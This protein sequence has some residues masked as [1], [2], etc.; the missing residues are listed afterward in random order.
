MIHKLRPAVPL[1][2]RHLLL[3]VIIL[4]STAGMGVNPAA[5]WIPPI[6]SFP[7]PQIWWLEA[8]MPQPTSYTTV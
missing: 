3:N 1:Q 5:A 7:K 4:A 2:V 8:H 6:L